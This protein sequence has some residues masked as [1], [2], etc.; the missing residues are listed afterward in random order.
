MQQCNIMVYASFQEHTKE[1]LSAC[2]QAKWPALGSPNQ[3]LTTCWHWQ[4]R[5]SLLILKGGPVFAQHAQF[6]S[7]TCSN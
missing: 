5:C 1:R 2:V 7:E 3:F 6:Q 4:C